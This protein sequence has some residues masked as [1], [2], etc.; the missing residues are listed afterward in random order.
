MK[1]TT[2][3]QGEFRKKAFRMLLPA[4]L[5]AAMSASAQITETMDTVATNTLIPTHETNNGFDN[6]S[7][8][9]SGSGDVR[10]TT[11][12]TGYGGASGGA[13]VFLNTGKTF[14]IGRL[15]TNSCGGAA[16]TMSFGIFKSTNAENGS[17]MI[18]EYSTN[19]GVS[20]SGLSFTALPTGGGTSHWY[21]RSVSGIPVTCNLQI[22]FRN[23]AI[24]GP[25]FR[26]DDVVISCG[27]PLQSAC[28]ASITANDTNVF[29]AGDSVRLTANAGDSYLWSPGGEI[30]QSI[31]VQHSGTYSVIVENNC[32]FATSAG[33]YVLVHNDG[34]ENPVIG[35]SVDNDTVCVGDSVT[36]S[37]RTFARNLFFSQ[38]M[39]GSSF[40]KAVEIYNGT[41]SSVNLA[42]YEIRAYHNGACDD[43]VPTFTISLTGT[44]ADGAVYIVAHPGN[45]TAITP[46]Q[47]SSSLQFNGDDAV[48]LYNT[49]TGEY[50]DIFGSICNDPGSAW[51][52]T[53]LYRTEDRTL[54]RRPCVYEGIFVNPNLPGASGFPTLTSEWIADT[55][56]VITGFGS[57]TM[58]ANVYNWTPQPTVPASGPVVRAEVNSTTMFFVDAEYCDGCPYTDSVRVVVNCDGEGRKAA[59]ASILASVNAE[60]Y[61]NPFNGNVVFNI[62]TVETG[63]MKVEVLNMLGETV[64][65]LNN[66]VVSAGK[67]TINWNGTADNGAVLPN[68]VYSCKVTAGNSVKTLMLVKSSK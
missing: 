59:P 65:V 13:N 7:L 6:D 68:G 39:E 49:F 41:G 9:F 64:A 27:D 54:T 23:A 5:L 51:T 35:A 26:I 19:G 62:T 11:V 53:G 67:Y 18:V 2:T 55:T 4:F 25:Q 32:C 14:V 1:T 38:Y 17:N 20:W 60:A 66:G 61:P 46:N 42:N 21:L 30:T 37:V 47:L 63:A 16:I 22:R 10:M 56:D 33:F 15:G 48:T 58:T 34:N 31:L 28:S 44:L 43:V 3:K 36:L 29:C 8:T 40:N 12:S 57:H 24:S 52:D 50:V 45:A